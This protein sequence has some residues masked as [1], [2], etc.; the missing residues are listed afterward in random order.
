MKK[1]PKCGAEFG[2]ELAFCQNCGTSL[3]AEPVAA[4]AEEPK[5]VPK[6]KA[7]A[8]EEK[9]K[10]SKKGL[11]FAIIGAVVVLAALVV[12]AILIFG[13][14]ATNYALYIKDR[15]IFFYNMKEKSEPWE[16]TSKLIDSSED[17]SDSNLASVG[18]TLGIYTYMSENGKY[19]FFPDKINDDGFGLYYKKAADPDGDAVKIDTSVES[20]FVNKAATLVIYLKEDN[21]YEYNISKGEKDK[22]ASDVYTYMASDD[23]KKVVYLTNDNDIYLKY[24]GEDKEK[25]AGEVS[26]IV[27]VNEALTTVYYLKD[28]A[29]YK[30]AEGQDK[31]K[32]DTDVYSVLKV[33]ESGEIYYIKH[34]EQIYIKDY[35]IDDKKEADA[36]IYAPTR[37]I[38][39]SYY[40]YDTY[41]E[42]VDAYERYQ[43][44]LEQ[45]YI[46]LEI[47]EGKEYR[48][49]IRNSLETATTYNSCDS[50]FYYTGTEVKEITKT[51]LRQSNYYYTYAKNAAVVAYEAYNPSEVAKVKLS[52]VSNIYDLRNK[53][54]DAL[55]SSY[56]KYIAVKGS[57]TALKAVK[58]ISSLTINDAGTLVY[59]VDNI[60]EDT[61][62]GDLYKIAVQGGKLGKAEKYDSE[63]GGNIRF[64]D[65]NTVMYVKDY[66][67]YVG[68]LYINKKKVDSDVYVSSVQMVDGKVY[69][70]ADYDSG[71]TCGTLKVYANG[72]TDKIADDVYDYDVEIDGQ[73]LYL[74]DYDTSSYEGELYAWKNGEKRK[75]DKDVSCIIHHYDTKYRGQ[76]YFGW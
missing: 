61:A 38:A 29:L 32:I 65:D 75:V 12:A 60:D 68:D 63:V 43:V 44:Q 45:Y 5:E 54:E 1:C 40:N 55:F 13:G 8:P 34:N 22:I 31:V 35:V 36:K 6:G 41:Q 70:Y 47:Y 57:A 27:F 58:S 56:A 73:V 20:Y 46:D 50:L 74:T 72:K 7:K 52:E 9:K 21:L 26:R 69:Y 33:Y 37:P 42:Y 39:P 30:K 2:D 17:I 48:D 62:S 71:D 15:E 59:Y 14:K 4:P 66:K 24:S 18:R 49:R 3:D 10:R 23:G 53:V 28:N 67:N 51:A 19:I 76:T 16:L 64:L 25:I 11:V